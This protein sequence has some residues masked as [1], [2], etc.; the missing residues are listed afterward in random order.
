M[1]EINEIQNDQASLDK[2]SKTLVDDMNYEIKQ[3]RIKYALLQKDIDT[4]KATNKQHILNIQLKNMTIVDKATTFNE[5]WTLH[6]AVYSGDIY[7][8]EHNKWHYVKNGMVHA[9]TMLNSFEHDLYK[10]NYHSLVTYNGTCEY[11][12]CYSENNTMWVYN[13][14][15]KSWH[16]F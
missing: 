15:S 14:N 10:L 5:H 2:Y 13:K 4:R 11:K 16:M 8:D 9:L 1:Q 6:V 12:F 3:I 7:A